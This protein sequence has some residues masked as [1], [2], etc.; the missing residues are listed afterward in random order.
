VRYLFGLALPALALAGAGLARLGAWRWPAAVVAGAGLVVPW[1]LGH[2]ALAAAWRDPAHAAR[3]WQVPPLEPVRD[4]LARAHVESAYA[5]LQFAGRLALET[6]EQVLASQAWNERIPGDPLR[7]RDEVD[8]DP[9]AAWVLHPHLSRGMPRAGGFRDLL[10]ELGGTWR[11]D[12]P[13]EFVIFRRFSPPYD[14]GRPVP[15]AALAVGLLDGTLLP[16]SVLDRNP[17]TVWTS[18]LGLARGSGLSVR[19]E[20]PRR[21]AAV[22]LAVG[23]E[24][25]PLAVP[26]IAEVD[27][28]PVA[29]GPLRHG[30]QWVNGVP[31]AGRQALLA[32][33]LGD[34]EARE[35]RLIFQGEGPVLVLS[36][37]VAYGPDEREQP[38][39]GRADAAAALASA[40]RGGWDDAVRLYAQ[41]LRLEP[42]R[43][44]Y[45]A[46]LARS[47]WRAAHRRRLDVESLSDGGPELVSPR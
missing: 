6:D 40:R 26:W 11:E 8:L 3:V 45:H 27:G 30:L 47:R 29:R 9:Q 17:D 28:T 19:I 41:A 15:A 18:R 4:T 22:V 35:V 46:C 42:D 5:S 37:V 24:P 13:G 31:R 25:T 20:P 10:R 36:E 1:A 34:R 23:L 16:A 33:P 7:F 38:S 44:A 32:V 43:A 14:E 2:R 21:L 12:L 39:A